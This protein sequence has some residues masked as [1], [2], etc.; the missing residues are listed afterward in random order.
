[1]FEKIQ[2]KNVYLYVSTFYFIQVSIIPT[3]SLTRAFKMSG[4]TLL[5]HLLKLQKKHL[6]NCDEIQKPLFIGMTL[7][8][9]HAF[10][11]S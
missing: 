7:K 3:L 8:R 11:I 2:I 9:Q 5:K 1:M 10:C 4:L 6:L